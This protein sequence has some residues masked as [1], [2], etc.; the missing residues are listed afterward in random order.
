MGY[1]P[2]NYDQLNLIDSSY[3]PSVVNLQQNK[4]FG[5][6]QR[7][8]FQ[9]AVSVLQIDLPEDW[10][11]ATKDFFLYCLFRYGYV[12]VFDY[13]GMGTIFNPCS[14]SGYDVFYRPTNA[15]IANPSFTKSLDLKIG[16]ECAVLKLCPDYM[17]VYDVV[18]YYAEKLA[19]LDNAIN[20]S[21][22]NNKYAF[23]LGAK[24]KGAANAL[25]KMLD[26][27]NDGEPAV[28]YDVKIADVDEK[29]GDPWH[30][31][32]RGNMKENYITTMQLSDFRTILNNF[33]SE[34]GIPTLA[35]EKKERMVTSEANATA[36]DSKS[37]V[38]VWIETF[39]SSAEV[40]N[41]MF[42]LNISC[43][44]REELE[45]GISDIDRT[46]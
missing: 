44:L 17:G 35:T 26:R 19:L 3:V 7:S 45:D 2:L 46:V 41:R 10:Q 14:L 12:A 28:I 4:S 20:M 6:W 25:K 42:N 15:L 1:M 16:E 27:I 33:D 36:L 30:V 9:R 8:L 21:L 22:I 29:N 37:R 39:N 32:N 18:N 13:E 11:G 43:K 40:A 23:M 38:R 5:F 24:S 34:I 31:W